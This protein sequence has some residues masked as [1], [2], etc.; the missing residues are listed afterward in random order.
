MGKYEKRVMLRA[1]LVGIGGIITSLIASTAGSDLTLNEV[2]IAIG[3][4]WTLGMGLATT[5]Y[6]SKTFNAHVGKK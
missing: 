6:F 5:E 1:I 3:S 2:F 4:G